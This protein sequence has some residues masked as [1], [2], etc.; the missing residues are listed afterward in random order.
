MRKI[1]LS[2]LM[3]NV[4]I[5]IVN[6]E[7]LKSITNRSLK[8]EYKTR[9]SYTKSVKEKPAVKQQKQV[10]IN[11][12]NNFLK[13]KNS[14][15]SADFKQTVVGQKGNIVSINVGKMNISRPNKFKWQYVDTKQCIISNGNYIYI[16]DEDLKQV[17]KKKLAGSLDRS[18]ALL[19]AGDSNIH[20]IYK[21]T[22]QRTNDNL[23]WVVLVPK[24]IDDNNG[25]KLVKIAFTKGQNPMLS[26]MYFEDNN[27][28]DK[29]TIEF[30]NVR[31]GDKLPVNSF[32]FIP[33]KGV[34]ILNAD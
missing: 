24:Q 34:E 6:A 15:I 19:L 21:V 4:T 16:Y 1:I 13:H 27:F 14:V 20:E 10:G 9:E 28:N 22:E 3:V 17:T 29:T 18:P 8:V 23:D 2:L 33:P 32:N 31:V 11:A 7:N 26:K 12:L 30:S 25:F 5:T